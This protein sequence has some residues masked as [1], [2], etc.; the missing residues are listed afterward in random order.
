MLI[1]AMFLFTLGLT[2]VAYYLGFENRD[3]LILELD[4]AKKHVSQTQ[5]DALALVEAA[6]YNM[7]ELHTRY[8]DMETVLGE[9][10]RVSIRIE[11]RLKLENNLLKET[12][13]NFYGEDGLKSVN[14]TVDTLTRNV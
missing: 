9:V 4:E 5:Q 1:T 6:N 12:I 13:R 8:V 10:N 2:G 11:N 7:R 14:N 3:S